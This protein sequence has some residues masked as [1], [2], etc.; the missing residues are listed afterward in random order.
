ME[1]DFSTLRQRVEQLSAEIALL[2]AQRNKG[3][4]QTSPWV[5]LKEAAS[6]LNFSSARALRNKIKSGHFPPD[7]YRVDPTALGSNPRYLIHVERYIMQ[8]R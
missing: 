2:K 5:P 7:C 1:P 8:L 4:G 6:R 3:Y